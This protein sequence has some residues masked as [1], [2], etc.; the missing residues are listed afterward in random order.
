MSLPLHSLW[1]SERLIE[2]TF[3]CSGGSEFTCTFSC[4][5]GSEFTCTF[6]FSGG[7]WSEESSTG[8][9]G[10]SLV[11]LQRKIANDKTDAPHENS[12]YFRLLQKPF[13][14]FIYDD[15]WWYLLPKHTFSVKAL[16]QC[17]VDLGRLLPNHVWECECW[18]H[19]ST[20]DGG[21]GNGKATH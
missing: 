20:V 2:F 11:Y 9:F 21:C 15:T 5:G 19:W 6:S 1:L 14:W 3:S 4:S 10:M 7:Q 13:C 8:P 18:D 16:T 17:N 12:C